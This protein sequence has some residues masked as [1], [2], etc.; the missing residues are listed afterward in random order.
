MHRR[1]RRVAADDFIHLS[2]WRALSKATVMPEEEEEDVPLAEEARL[3]LANVPCDLDVGGD[4]SA[5]EGTWRQ[6][7]LAD[8]SA[9]T[10][11]DA[12]FDTM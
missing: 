12:T 5:E 10:G 1:R 9:S 11:N 7:T 8:R 2:A 3:P 4:S 6:R